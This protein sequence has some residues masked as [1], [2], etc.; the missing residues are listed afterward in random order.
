ME[1]TS[2][3]SFG[4]TL[5]SIYGNTD[6]F[7]TSD[8][9][10]VNLEPRSITFTP[11]GLVMFATNIQARINPTGKTLTQQAT[12]LTTLL[13][14]ISKSG[15]VIGSATITRQCTITSS[16]SIITFTNDSTLS[17]VEA[18]A[19]SGCTVTIFAGADAETLTF[20]ENRQYVRRSANDGWLVFTTATQ[21]FIET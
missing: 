12:E 7:A 17:T 19:I 11:L 1:L 8:S 4:A 21:D 6:F 15:T 14:T 16:G 20:V 5:N 10:V 13:N 2:T 18:G 9:S 3:S